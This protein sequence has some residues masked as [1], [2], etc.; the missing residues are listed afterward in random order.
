MTIIGCKHPSE[1][2]V[3]EDVNKILLSYL[4]EGGSTLPGNCPHESFIV[5]SNMTITNVEVVKIVAEAEL[6]V[7]TSWLTVAI[8]LELAPAAV[9]DAYRT[10][11]LCIW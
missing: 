6:P 1:P 9:T 7:N 11:A 5:S 4:L 3:R 10:L 8:A 2:V